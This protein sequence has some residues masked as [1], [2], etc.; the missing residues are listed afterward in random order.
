MGNWATIAPKPK[1][2][3]VLDER[4]GPIVMVPCARNQARLTTEV[5]IE[6]FK[7]GNGRYPADSFAGE[8]FVGCKDC[9]T[10]AARKRGVPETEV[11]KMTEAAMTPT[12]QPVM[13]IKARDCKKCGKAFEP[14]GPTDYFC[15]D[16]CRGKPK[17]YRSSKKRKAAKPTKPASTAV[18]PIKADPVRHSI[19][20]KPTNP[21]QAREFLEL[22]GYKVQEI[23]T[24]AGVLL[25]LL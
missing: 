11:T 24:P 9:P 2:L 25:K 23:N 14:S 22:G 19:T 18:I 12:T 5:C 1:R 16:E 20:P 6:R 3:A 13:R 17:Q 7:R 21:M 15:G 4:K 10:G 8:P